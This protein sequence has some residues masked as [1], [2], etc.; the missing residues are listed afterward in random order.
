[1]FINL[2]T[3]LGD[4]SNRNT[5]QTVIATNGRHS[6]TI[7]NYGTLMWSYTVSAENHAL[8]GFNSGENGVYYQLNGSLTS[9]IL[10]ISNG[11]NVDVT[12]KY[13]FRIDESSIESGGCIEDGLLT[14]SPV[15]VFFFGNQ[16]IEVSGPCFEFNDS[17]K[18]IYGDNAA[19]SVQCEVYDFRKSLCP[20]PILQIVGRIP[21]KLVINN[22]FTFTGFV[23][24]KEI[25]E[26]NEIVG[27]EPMYAIEDIDDTTTR[28]EWP[29]VMIFNFCFITL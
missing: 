13:I 2:F 12:G 26:N 20:V 24:S 21:I 29:G 28:I 8:A 11:S 19:Q 18:L 25:N 5:F 4:T 16:Q 6:F 15:A 7:F 14:V 3:Y 10:K 17:V 27:L 9:N 1:M 22:N 23:I